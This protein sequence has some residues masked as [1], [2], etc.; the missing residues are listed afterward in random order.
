M[1]TN[2]LLRQAKLAEWAS[3]IS[4]QKASGLNVSAWCRQN[5]I[6]KD[7]FFYWKRLLKDE[8]ITQMLPDI[9]PITLPA[10][11]MPSS[12]QPI[13]HNPSIECKNC[14]T[15]A[16]FTPTPIARVLINGITIELNSNAS[17]SFIKHLIKAVRYV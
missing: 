1:S 14:T 10:E 11:P 8:A 2:S 17:E 9:V 7:K 4:D 13:S 6:S 16:T 12:P 3:R 15:C 5:N